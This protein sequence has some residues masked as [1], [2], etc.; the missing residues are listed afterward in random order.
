MSKK[1]I[2]LTRSNQSAREK[3]L[4]NEGMGDADEREG[5]VITSENPVK[6]FAGETGNERK[7]GTIGP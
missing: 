7:G 1:K 2:A 6:W 3:V 4:E 5:E